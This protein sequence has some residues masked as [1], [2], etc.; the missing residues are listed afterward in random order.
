MVDFCN[1][2]GE[3]WKLNGG[4]IVSGIFVYLVT[5]GNVI[6]KYRYLEKANQPTFE[7]VLDRVVNATLKK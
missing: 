4:R 2:S 6:V 5:L 3:K 7:S 1:P